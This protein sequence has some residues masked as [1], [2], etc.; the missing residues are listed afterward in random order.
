MDVVTLQAAKASAAAQLPSVLTRLRAVVIGDSTD[1]GGL[2]S[3]DGTV[4][5]VG[6]SW[7]TMSGI[8][9]QQA[10]NSS[11][12]TWACLLSGG[13]LLNV[14]NGG[15]A[16]DNT[17]GMIA[18]FTTDVINNKPDVL[19]VGSAH[20]DFSVGS[21]VTQQQTRDNIVTMIR[22]ARLKGIIPI[23]STCYPENNATLAP[24]IRKHNAWLKTLAQGRD[25]SY[26]DVGHMF[27]VDRYAAVVDP[28]SSTGAWLSSYTSDG[29]HPNVA[30]G[31]AVGNRVLA[32]LAG[33]LRGSTTAFSPWL[34]TDNVQGSPN[35]IFNGL[36]QND[37]NSDGLAD[38]WTISGGTTTPTLVTDSSV[39]GK[40][41]QV[42]VSAGAPLI[43][44]QISIDGTNIQIGDRLKWVGLIKVAGSSGSLNFIHQLSFPGV[45][46]YTVQ[47]LT[48]TVGVDYGWSYYEVE[49]VVPTS[50][51]SLRAGG[52]VVAG[53]GTVSFAQQALY[54][55]TRGF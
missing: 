24:V 18:R 37:A 48:Q 13:R 20:N 2:K 32:D 11:W 12:F 35:R 49:A 15:I 28:A 40:A 14:Y 17:P 55:M 51:T 16:S 4:V 44:Q 34:P 1:A 22:R 41:Q 10:G 38:S 45:S 33:L 6:N 21:T 36:F 54:N 50:A 31:M 5:Q 52:S 26:P 46:S 53:T 8:G 27:L 39:V 43:Y 25:S 47:P 9:T 30:G 19:F 7:A 3:V 29:T 42:V 23:L